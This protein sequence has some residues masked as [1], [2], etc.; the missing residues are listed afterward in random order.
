MDKNRWEQQIS[1]HMPNL[2]I[3][4]CRHEDWASDIAANNK[5]QFI[6]ALWIERQW[7]FAQQCDQSRYGNTIFYSINSYRYIDLNFENSLHIILTF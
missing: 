2:R 6:S 5:S 7:S 1:S 3:F 4:D